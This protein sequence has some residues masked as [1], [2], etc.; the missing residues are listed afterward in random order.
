VQTEQNVKP[1]TDH[2]FAVAY[3]TG[4]SDDPTVLAPLVLALHFAGHG[5]PFYGRLFLED[6]VA[7]ALDSLGA[8]I[9]APDCTA[10]S[11]QDRKS[12]ADVV[13]LLDYVFD[14]YPVDRR[15]VLVVGYSMGGNGAWFLAA[16]HPDIFSAA[17]IV[18]G[19]PPVDLK[20]VDW[21]VPTYVLHS[22]QDEF[23]PLETTQDAV[24]Y[25]AA[26]GAE[27][28]IKILD[29]I[30]HFETW[31]FIEPLRAIVPWVQDIWGNNS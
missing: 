7:P 14:H 8:I 3:P 5:S 4:Y 20:T 10:A 29:G 15:R 13:N 17:V 27:I 31:R 24:D 23:V 16:H 30:T 9:L 21:Q 6:L 22:R 2:R 28:E 26:Q 18:S 12:E 19:W 25:L 1:D 11:W